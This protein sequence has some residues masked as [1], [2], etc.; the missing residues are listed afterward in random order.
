M[1]CKR[2]AFSENSFKAIN[3]LFLN[4]THNFSY[5][6]TSKLS[7]QKRPN[8]RFNVNIQTK[9]YLTTEANDQNSTN[10]SID[11][12]EIKKFQT[13]ADSWWVENGEFE[14]LHRLNLLRV[15]L[16]RDTLV[17]Y[18]NSLSETEKDNILRKSD[19]NRTQYTTEELIRE[20]L[21]G[22]NILDI[23]CGG[24]ILSEVFLNS[25]SIGILKFEIFKYFPDFNLLQTQRA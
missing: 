6:L 24:G 8:L 1:L 10:S 2:V 11:P 18:R 21:L 13:L 9:K 17:N 7:I 14:A 12:E 4:A 5:K 15:P 3:K 23:G 19:E 20:P 22:L 16:I 25:I